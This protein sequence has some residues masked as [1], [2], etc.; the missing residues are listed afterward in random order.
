MLN[1]QPLFPGCFVKVRLIGVVKA[2]Q[3]KHA[4]WVRNDRLVGE[5]L[6][7]ELPLESKPLKLD[8]HTVSQIEFFFSS[9][10]SLFGQRFRVI[11]IGGPQKAL[12]LTRQACVPSNG[13]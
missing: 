9:Y 13:E 7:K 3:T 4:R 8:K 10:N 12:E 6:G 2:E 1:E 5:A 11:G